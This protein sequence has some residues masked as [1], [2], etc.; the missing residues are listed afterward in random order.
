MMVVKKNI[1]IFL[2]FLLIGCSAKTPQRTINNDMPDWI[3]HPNKNGH[4][5]A[6]GVAARTYDQSISTQR[7]LAIS[8]ALDELSL[9]KNVKVTLELNRNEHFKNAHL[10]VDMKTKSSY[11]TSTNITAHIQDIWQ[12]KLTGQLYVWMVVTQ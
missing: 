8:R 6:I 1:I 7:K 3:L 2:V 5:G 4:I 10:D 9:E 11:H 12:N